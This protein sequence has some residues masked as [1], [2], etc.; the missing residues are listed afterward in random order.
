M[1]KFLA[2]VFIFLAFTTCT[3]AKDTQNKKNIKQISIDAINPKNENLKGRGFLGFRGKDQLVIYTPHYGNTTNTD[4]K[5]VEL[6]V[7]NN[8]VEKI[9]RSNS[10]IPQDGYVVSASGKAKKFINNN[11]FEGAFIDLDLKKMKLKTDITPSD[12]TQ[13]AQFRID[14]AKEIMENS[15]EKIINT[16]NM[17]FY[18]DKAEDLMVA[19]KKIVRFG[20]FEEAQKMAKD[21]STYSDLALYSSVDFKPNEYRGVWVVPYQKNMDEIQ[22][23]FDTIKHL[24]V[25][26]IFIDGF[27]KGFTIYPS[28][29]MTKYG[30]LSQLH[31]YN[32][33]DPLAVWVALAHEAGIKVHLNFQAF[34]V[35]T[36]DPSKKKDH[37]ITKHKDWVNVQKKNYL[38]NEPKPSRLEDNNYFLDPSNEEVQQFLLSL[39][40]EAIQKYEIDGISVNYLKYP[41]LENRADFNETW[42]Y[43]KNARKEFK[44]QY[45]IDPVSLT[46]NSSNL[47]DWNKYRADKISGFVK[48]LETLKSLKDNIEISLSV[49]PD[50]EFAYQD[51]KNWGIKENNY[52]LLPQIKSS[53]EEYSKIILTEIKNNIGEDAK[54]YPIYYDAYLEEKP[55]CLFNKIRTSR[56]IGING[57]ILYDYDSISKD[58]YDALRLCTFR[59]HSQKKQSHIYEREE[60]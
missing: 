7:K 25:E 18:I 31:Y 47:S 46:K 32:G 45:N 44:G 24:H 38:L 23:A 14:N 60:N 1:K 6:V 49:S 3:Y 20:D 12:Y 33:F 57:I 37:I 10:Y 55:R 58:Y 28:E 59:E 53:D 54:I 52:M 50:N 36:A 8:R 34:N 48:K 16:S 15:D 51:Y 9:N 19:S 41:D 13:M 30:S 27:Y 35:G 2:F 56:E 26:N 5:G 42:G 17:Q 22:E 39:M 11:L 43:T 21:S 40:E 29:V 4:S